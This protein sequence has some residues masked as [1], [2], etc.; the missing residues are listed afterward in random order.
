VG[1]NRAWEK[2]RT[3]AGIT[4]VRL[5]DL[6]HSFATFAVENGASLFQVGRALGH[7]KSVSTER[8]AHPTDAGARA[9]ASDVAARFVPP[10][11]PPANDDGPADGVQADLFGAPGAAAAA[12]RAGG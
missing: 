12:A 11:A 9:I 7:A 1:V 6:R 4:D 8:Y 5:H 2:V 3:L 10:S